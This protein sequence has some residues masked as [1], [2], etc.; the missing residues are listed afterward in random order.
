MSL[1]G[2]ILFFVGG[3]LAFI[4]GVIG[5]GG[6]VNLAATVIGCALLISGSVFIGSAIVRRALLVTIMVNGRQI[7]LKPIGDGRFEG[8]GDSVQLI[9][10]ASLEDA[11]AHYSKV[12]T[13][14][15]EGEE[16]DSQ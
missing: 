11:T 8:P 9:H 5:I 6:V 13:T 7:T 1:F 10:F 16:H 15:A 2:W 4:N 3:C 14:T 12:S